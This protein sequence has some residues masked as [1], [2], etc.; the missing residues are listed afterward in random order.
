MSPGSK[1]ADFTKTGGAVVRDVSDTP[2]P[3][4]RAQAYQEAQR[5]AA[6][7]TLPPEFNQTQP[8]AANQQQPEKPLS[9]PPKEQKAEAPKADP[10]I[11]A[12]K[13][14]LTQVNAQLAQTAQTQQQIVANSADAAW[15][16]TMAEYESAAEEFDTDRMKVA[17]EKLDV[18]RQQPQP[19]A[20]TATGWAQGDPQQMLQTIK[21]E[22]DAM[23]KN[24]DPAWM[25]EANEFA[26]SLVPA[27]FPSAKA[28]VDA[29]DS[30]IQQKTQPAAVPPAA[31]VA[32]AG[33]TP[34]QMGTPVGAATT[35]E[36]SSFAQLPAD[37]RAASEQL[38]MEMGRN[39][40][41]EFEKQELA[42][43]NFV[44]TQAEAAKQQK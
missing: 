23:G 41:E 26:K 16:A 2:D 30:A 29:I 17:R 14:Q 22:V 21:S 25:R 32:P 1:I 35:S 19:V 10:E 9:L 15:S 39:D 42:S 8:P 12:L 18:L 40:R 6:P 13:A 28:Y 37:V 20:P 36:V 11:A 34:T 38:Y 44:Q 24:T 33:P 3:N 7:L 27:D 5:A 43:Y 4:P 31:A